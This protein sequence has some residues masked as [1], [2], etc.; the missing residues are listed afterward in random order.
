MA[1]QEQVLDVLRQVIDPDFRKDIV[2]LGFVKNL[3]I[4]GGRVGF[5]IELTTPACP[6]KTQFQQEA[7]NLVGGLPG[8]EVV[9]VNMTSRAPAKQQQMA[10][11]DGVKSIIAVASAKGGVGKSTMAAAIAVEIASRGYQVGLLDADIFGPS[12]PTLFNQ[13]NP[14]IE[15]K[16]EMIQPLV[17][18]NLKLMSFGFLLGDSPAIMRGPMVSGYI[19]QLLK[20]VEWGELDYLF[21][22]MPPG[23]GDTQLTVSQA[24]ALD[25]A[26]IVTTRSGLSLVDVSRGIL[27]FEKVKVPMLGIIENMAYFICDECD[28]KHYVFGGESSMLTERFGLSTL[29]HVPLEP[30]RLQ[31]LDRYE[32]VPVIAEMVDDLLREVGRQQIQKQ[33][34]PKIDLND[35]HVVFSWDDEVSAVPYATLRD[36]CACAY[37]IDEYTGE[38]ILKTDQIPADIKILEAFPLG[39]YAVSVQWSDGHSSSIYPY[40][41]LKELHEP[42]LVG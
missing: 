7:E 35:D 3:K 38:K 20:Q 15:Q 16:G 34:P 32:S 8:V 22:D 29:A 2:S 41:K 39:N 28:K 19:Q 42:K 17:L 40:A 36:N 37:C 23:T 25:G 31:N 24:V 6:V 14:R 18:G 21:I 9:T 12:V 13:H 5:D 10:Q 11:L 1:T 33:H 30:G 4:D 27:M 26:V